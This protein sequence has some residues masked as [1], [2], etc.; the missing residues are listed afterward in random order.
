M[1]NPEQTSGSGA[2]TAQSGMSDQQRSEFFGDMSDAG[3][4]TG[5]PEGSK[6]Q[7]GSEQSKAGDPDKA[8]TAKKSGSDAE[9]K[10]QPR[11]AGKYHTPEALEA[12]YNS[13]FTHSQTLQT[14]NAEL[15]RK[16]AELQ[17]A[18]PE[19]KKDT[20]VDG[21]T[22]NDLEG[23]LAKVR[24]DHAAIRQQLLD[25]LGDETL[26]AFEK[27]NL[28]LSSL[29]TGRSDPELEQL[30]K[31]LA[32]ERDKRLDEEFYSRMP[33]AKDPIVQEEIEKLVKEIGEKGSDPV[34]QRQLLAQA[35]IGRRASEIIDKGI[36]S[37]VKSMSEKDRAA[38]LASHLV[39]G[40]TTGGAGGEKGVNLSRQEQR[41]TFFADMP[42]AMS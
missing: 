5:D 4:A 12:G 34:F 6:D 32:M 36:L 20:K 14:E 7:S 11:Y 26:E 23:A 24:T 10:D 9:S 2:E 37:R 31:E 13:L 41:D 38:F 30:K 42:G 21:P 19:D 8:T 29:S 35:A 18:K 27:Y 17:A 1:P 15:R 39:A 40:D 33:E 25:V 28:A 22:P 3:P 16:F